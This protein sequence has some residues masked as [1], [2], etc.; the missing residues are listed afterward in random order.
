MINPA[1]RRRTP[2]GLDM[3]SVICV[4]QTL[5]AVAALHIADHLADGP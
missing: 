2:A 1:N 4:A 5:R 3:L